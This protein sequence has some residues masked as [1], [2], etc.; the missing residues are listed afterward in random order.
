MSNTYTV[1]SGDTLGSIAAANKCSVADLR[2]LNPIITDPNHIKVGWVLKLPAAKALP[3]PKHADNQSTTAVKGAVECKDE[4]VDVVHITGDEH[5]YVLTEKESKDL[6]QQSDLVK[7]LMDELHQNLA[8]ATEAS[9]CAKTK[10]PQAGC[11]CSRCV[12]DDWNAK[13]E[14]A[15]LLQRSPPP[16]EKP[17]TVI[18]RKEDL[19]GQLATVQE[20]RDWY[21]RYRPQPAFEG[22]YLETNWEGLQAKKVAELNAE[23]QSLRNRI[24]A[25]GKAEAGDSSTSA[26]GAA[27][28]IKHGKGKASDTQ[29]GKQVK[30][31]IT[32]VEYISFRDPSRRHYIPVR[33]REQLTWSVKVPI[34]VMQGKPLDKNLAKDLIKDIRT[35][36]NDGRKTSPLGSLE[37]KFTSWTSKDDN[38]LNALHKEC[39]WTSNEADSAMYAV[40][41]EAHAFRFAATASAGIN[42]W[43]PGKGNIELGVKGSAAISLAEGSVALKSYFPDQGGYV[44][45]MPYRNA[46]GKEVVSDIGI[47]RLDGKVELS[48]FLGATAQGQAGAKAQYKPKEVEASGVT[49][50]LSTPDLAVDKK[51][52]GSL[53]LKG[54]AFAGVQGGGTVTGTLKWLDST[55]QGVGKITPGQANDSG[56]TDW[57]SL[58]EIKAEGNAALGIG[59]GFD[60]GIEISANRLAI[61]CKAS[62]VFGPGAGGGFGTS[63]D[64]E[65]IGDLIYVFCNALSKADFHYQLAVTKDAFSYMAA[66][67]YKIATNPGESVASAFDGGFRKMSAWWKQRESTKQ[68]AQNL[69]KYLI[70]NQSIQI[71]KKTIPLQKLPPQTVGPMLHLLTESFVDSWAEDQEQAIVLLLSHLRSWRHFIEALEHCSKNGEKVNSMNSL[72]RINSILDGAEQQQFNRFIK[73][74]A[75]NINSSTIEYGTLA[76]SP[77][78][79]WRKERTLLAA[80]RSNS[81]VGLA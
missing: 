46:E 77:S 49:A 42:S 26:N 60:F 51:R 1:K 29:K 71:G 41:A 17:K 57:S 76:W 18:E 69:A 11:S 5:F 32:V 30:T 39:S 73:T 55:K 19:Q 22:N 38:L 64:I 63:V 47:F 27:P 62:L 12:K 34:K 28:D 35:A 79:P 67:L 9:K 43:E 66:G 21:Q 24:A 75:V 52:G 10:D 59:A 15:G 40:S 33:T 45:R 8:K 44:V 16:V 13:A 36:V 68:D 37:A 53:G 25:Q 31:G 20:A 48:C 50:L 23:I 81:F 7:K 58:V 56:S 78:P 72:N 54:N 6:K 3:P 14:E 74:L 70:K 80:R 61:N 65:K 2:G 4:L